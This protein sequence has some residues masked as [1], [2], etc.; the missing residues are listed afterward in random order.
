MPTSWTELNSPHR[1]QVTFSYP[2]DWTV[3]NEKSRD[4][5]D[6]SDRSIV[7]VRSSSEMPIFSVLDCAQWTGDPSDI[8]FSSYVHDRMD[9][10]IQG[11]L[12]AEFLGNDQGLV[13]N[14]SKTAHVTTIK[15][16][17]IGTEYYWVLH[18][19]IRYTFT[20]SDLADRFDSPESKQIR[21]RILDT[22]EFQYLQ[23]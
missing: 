23:D 21:D 3:S 19:G 15:E 14:S 11:K 16:N 13:S 2:S 20:Y 7:S 1:C 5:F 9:K 10:I 8:V 22:L 12:F 4:R 18:N 17:D 6:T